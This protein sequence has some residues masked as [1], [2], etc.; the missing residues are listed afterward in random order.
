MKTDP[1]GLSVERKGLRFDPVGLKGRG[2]R[3][4]ERRDMV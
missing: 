3:E 2:M 4:G 1:V